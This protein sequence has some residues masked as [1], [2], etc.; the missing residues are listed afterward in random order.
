MNE[1]VSLEEMLPGK[2]QEPFKVILVS[3]EVLHAPCLDF[4][5]DFA[6]K[7]R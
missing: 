1:V 3:M 4:H 7:V 5:P 2:K 6:C